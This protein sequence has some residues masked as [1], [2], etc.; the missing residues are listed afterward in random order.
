MKAGAT[1]DDM[2][3]LVDAGDRPLG[4]A[5][6][7]DA[8]R[9]GLTH[10]AVSALVRNSAGL[11]LLQRRAAG[12][13]HSAGLWTNAC[14]SHPRPDESAAAAAQR[15]LAEEMGVDCPLI[16]LFTTRYRAAVSNDLIEDEVVHVFAGIHDGRV[17]PD[18]AE[19][20]EWKWM[21]LP[22]LAADQLTHPERYTVWFLHYLRDHRRVI[23][24]WLQRPAAAGE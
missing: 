23:A 7:L 2:V 22:E 12:K 8:H 13:Y 21:P 11:I 10:R 1:D 9:R 20:S 14:C 17:T 6:K 19:V 24:D 16:P 5:P 4:T 15:R 3:I 18:A